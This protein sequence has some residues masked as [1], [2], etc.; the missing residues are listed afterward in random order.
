MRVAVL[1]GLGRLSL[2]RQI[3]ERLIR[4]MCHI[5]SVTYLLEL[6]EGAR[7]AWQ[8]AF[9]VFARLFGQGHRLLGDLL[10]YN[11]ADVIADGGLPVA[12]EGCQLHGKVVCPVLGVLLKHQLH[13]IDLLRQ[14]IDGLVHLLTLVGSV[15]GDGALRCPTFPG[16]LVSENGWCSLWV[17]G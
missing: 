1:C 3:S 13:L 10:A 8:Q 9:G 2:R 5:A 17:E 14:Q 4:K 7:L 16:K 6:G 11:A 12:A 15:F